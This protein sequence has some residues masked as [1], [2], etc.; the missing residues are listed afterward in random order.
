M[1][2]AAGVERFE[3]GLWE[4]TALLLVGDGESVAVDPGVT[5]VEIERIR[6]AANERGAP[7]RTVLATHSHFDHVCGIG[8]FPDAEAVMGEATAAAVAD[9]TAATS[10]A[11]AA[12]ELGLHWEGELRCDRA[13]AL[14]RAHR[15]GPFAAETLALPGHSG[16]GGAFRFRSLD[17]LV[18]GD[19]VSAAEFPFVYQG[20]AEYRA[21]LAALVDVLRRDPPAVVASGHGP[22]LDAAGALAVAEADLDYLYRL[23]DAVAA[24]LPQGEEAAHAAGLAVE[25]PRPAWPEFHDESLRG[26]VDA[27]LAEL[28]AA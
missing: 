22:L 3:S 5:A 21:T 23:R 12:A 15:I 8:A 26:N 2:G 1:T 16:C 25:P 6:A 14:G 11:E 17:L 18:V 28:R 4:T 19:H 27:Q 13:L 7:V 10:L 20:T 24:A 9:G